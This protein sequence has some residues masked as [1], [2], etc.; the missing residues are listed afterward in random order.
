MSITTNGTTSSDSSFT[1]MDHQQKSRRSDQQRSLGPD[2]AEPSP[3]ADPSLIDTSLPPP[4]K[5]SVPG[6]S[7]DIIATS[8]ETPGNIFNY[9][10]QN[11]PRSST[12]TSADAHPVVDQGLSI[13]KDLGDDVRR[14]A[15][16]V[17]K[18][19]EWIRGGRGGRTLG[20]TLPNQEDQTGREGL[21]QN[22]ERDHTGSTAMS[23][24][25][26]VKL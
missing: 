25:L 5:R 19:L 10:Q 8:G 24:D 13:L 20:M 21:M 7:F 2:Y 14:A 6:K 4:P 16:G 26:Q 1:T 18:D 9:G 17:G 3:F 12:L 15:E 22:V 11:G 23:E